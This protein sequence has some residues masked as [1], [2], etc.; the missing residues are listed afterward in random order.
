MNDTLYMALRDRERATGRKE[1][2]LGMRQEH[3]ERLADDWREHV[4]SVFG[5]PRSE[6][7]AERSKE[8]EAYAPQA[9]ATAK[10]IGA[11]LR[12]CN[13]DEM[14]VLEEA[15]RIEQ[16]MMVTGKTRYLR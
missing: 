7:L 1:F 10:A 2:W 5:V 14:L 13:R 4:A 6:R 16:R 9:A 8:I 11:L 15:L 3:E 12:A